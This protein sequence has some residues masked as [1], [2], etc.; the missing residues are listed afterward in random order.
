MA[1]SSDIRKDNK[2]KIYRLMLDHQQY[3]KQQ[4]SVKTGL[5]VATCNTLLNDMAANK[6]LVIGEEKEFR[7]VGRSSWLYEIDDEHE[8]Y[9]L[10]SF[11][12]NQ[13][14]RN[15]DYYVVSATGNIIRKE[16]TVCE[17]ID[18]ENVISV[19]DGLISD[20]S[21]MKQI[22]L[23]IPGVIDGA[24]IEFCDIKELEIAD[25][26]RK[27]QEHFKLIVS[28]ENDMHCMAYGYGRKKQLVNEVITLAGFPSHIL[29]GTVTMHK[30]QIISGYNGIAGLAGFMPF[31]INPD[32]VPDM[33][34]EGKCLD[35]ISRIIGAIIAFQNPNEIVFSGDLINN[36]I[37]SEVKDYCRRSI[38]EKYM[39]VFKM[40]SGFSEYLIEGMFQ[41]AVENKEL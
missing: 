5:S 34:V 20:C 41:I 23:G 11:V 9:I 18:C 28:M 19:I 7:G 40:V 16:C 17:T 29:P 36:R 35:I 1:N 38:P 21:S 15:V 22:V 10:V 37:L 27:L 31:G 39:P 32:E 4:I 2:K 3:T 13:G 25:I 14:M 30:G 24:E 12:V 6:V 26:K 8:H 33:M